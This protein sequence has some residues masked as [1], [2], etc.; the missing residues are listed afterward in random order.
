MRN[1]G[2]TC[3]CARL[4]PGAGG[5]L[6]AELVA[7]A[8]ADGHTL[9]VSALSSLAISASLYKAPRYSLLKDLTPVAVVASVPN[10]LV[11]NPAVKANNVQE[12]LAL[13]KAN[14]GKI[15]FGSAGN[16][17]TVHFA[18]ELFKSLANVNM[19]HIPYKGAAPA[20]ADLLGG[21]VQIMFDFL[22]AAAPQI[23]SGKLRALGVTGTTRSPL[24]PDVPTIAEA[25]LPGYAVL[26][27]FGVMA[28]AGT[29]VDIINLLNREIANV[30]KMPEVKERLAASAATPEF[31][32]PDELSRTLKSEVTK[33]AKIV[34]STGVRLD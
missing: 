27:Q 8:P 22:S 5:N 1:A 23:K 34:D 7:R 20:M 16:G 28:P 26:G 31:G 24:L 2:S 21:Q 15:N 3:C 33:W 13:I 19:V 32:T 6:A 25:G 17:T 12:L 29:P 4:C 30:V 18:G 9:L 10:V 11:V 14:P